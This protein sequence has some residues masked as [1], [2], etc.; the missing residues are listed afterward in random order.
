MEVQDEI[1]K[2]ATSSGTIKKERIIFWE[3][4]LQI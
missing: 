2:R 3:N 4:M 1:E